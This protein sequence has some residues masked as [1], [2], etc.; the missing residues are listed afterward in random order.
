MRPG[1][2]HRTRAR[3]R[4]LGYAPPLAWDDDAID[5]P[6]AQPC[7]GNHAAGSSTEEP[8]VDQVA[9]ERALAGRSL[10]G[11]TAAERLAAVAHLAGQ[12]V[13]TPATV[14]Y[15]L[16]TSGTVARRLLRH[17]PQAAQPPR[18]ANVR[19]AAAQ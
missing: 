6:S 8:V 15:R 1:P 7:P 2:S 5:D 9:V 3:A 4:A 17:L 16:G 12:G 13:S 18:L 14:A 19:Q 10:A 11:L